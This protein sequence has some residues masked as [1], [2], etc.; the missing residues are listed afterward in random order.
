MPDETDKL[1]IEAAKLI[2]ARDAQAETPAR[3]EVTE[4]ATP[5]LGQTPAALGVP[6]EAVAGPTP[7]PGKAPLTTIDEWEGLPQKEQLARM[8]ELDYLIAAGAK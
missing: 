5:E 8:D 2:V 7:P 1:I 4:P 6:A 3:P